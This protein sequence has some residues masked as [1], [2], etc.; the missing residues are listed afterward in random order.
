MT[1]LL[2]PGLAGAADR[3]GGH[4]LQIGK[5]HVELVVKDK[6]LVFCVRD[7]GDKPIDSKT[8]KATA[9]KH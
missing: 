4:E 9:N 5:H 1:V 3:Q 2:A 8:I 7:Q 6:E